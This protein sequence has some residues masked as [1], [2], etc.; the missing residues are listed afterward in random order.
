MDP[1]E[2]HTFTGF[3]PTTGDPVQDQLTATEA[4]AFVESVH[5]QK[6]EPLPD[7]DNV[8]DV[9]PEVAS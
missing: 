5:R 3:D 2:K 1:N 4:E 6:G 8:L 9:D 7:P